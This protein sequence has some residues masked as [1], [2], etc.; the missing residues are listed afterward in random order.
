MGVLFGSLPLGTQ[1][2]A[3][4]ELN[5]VRSGMPHGGPDMSP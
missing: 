1:V 2:S 5:V 3:T 4:W